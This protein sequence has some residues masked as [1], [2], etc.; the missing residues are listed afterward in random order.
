MASINKVIL[1]GNLGKD[2]DL[3]YTPGG[4]AV[5]NFPIATNERWKDKN[6]QQQE[7]TEW[8][9]IV[10]WGRLAEIANDYLRKGSSVY[11]E[12]RLQTRSWEDRDGNKRY[13]TEVVGNQMQMLGRQADVGEQAPRGKVEG[14]FGAEPEPPSESGSD[15]VDDDLPF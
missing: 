2:P 8:H 10:L 5:V 15:Q 1:I 11:I 7:R 4:S 6:G 9:N 3:R 12:G 13:T 14:D